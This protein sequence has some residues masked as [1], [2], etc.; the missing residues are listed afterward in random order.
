[1]SSNRPSFVIPI[2]NFITKSF[3]LGSFYIFHA[4]EQIAPWRNEED[5]VHRI[6][7]G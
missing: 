3:V 1:M 5:L 7:C 2:K 6:I 4:N